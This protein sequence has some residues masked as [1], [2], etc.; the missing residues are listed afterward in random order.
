MVPTLPDIQDWIFQEGDIEVAKVPKC[1]IIF[2][3]IK[4]SL[5]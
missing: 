1:S 3:I 4:I 5:E 2:I